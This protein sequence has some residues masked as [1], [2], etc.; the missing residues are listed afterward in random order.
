MPDTF[1]A[2]AP[3]L[4]AQESGG[5]GGGFPMPVVRRH[6]SHAGASAAAQRGHASVSAATRAATQQGH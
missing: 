4:P 2:P 3:A 1:S 5:G 6:I